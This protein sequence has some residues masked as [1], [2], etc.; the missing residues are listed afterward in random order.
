MFRLLIVLTFLIVLFGAVGCIRIPGED[1]KVT[2]E[3]YNSIASSP[4]LFH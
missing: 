1:Q 4:E 2:A 3:E